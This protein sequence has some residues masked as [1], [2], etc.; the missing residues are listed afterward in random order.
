MKFQNP[1]TLYG[2]TQ[3]LHHMGVKAEYVHRFTDDEARKDILSHLQTGNP[4][5]IEV[6]RKNYY[7]GMVA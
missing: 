6:G 1:I 4:V 3:A 5:V 2:I 7:T